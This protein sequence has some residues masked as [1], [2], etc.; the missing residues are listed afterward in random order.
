MNR[1]QSHKKS[2]NIAFIVMYR[3]Q[4]VSALEDAELFCNAELFCTVITD[5]IIGMISLP[6]CK[7]NVAFV[8]ALAEPESLCT[9]VSVIVTGMI[10]PASRATTNKI[11]ASPSV[12]HIHCN[13]NILGFLNL[14]SLLF[15]LLQSRSSNF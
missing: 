8:A 6:H 2:A 11:I 10:T 7:C 13:P 14:A 1:Y 3:H 15:P 9:V 5:T 12:F 4:F